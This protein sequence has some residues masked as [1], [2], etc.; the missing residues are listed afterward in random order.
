MITDSQINFLYLADTLPKK[1]PDFYECFEQVLKS[2]KI[3]FALLP[4]TKDVWAVDYM[5]IQTAP[6]RFVR[7]LYRPPYLTESKRDVKTISDV[8]PVLLSVFR[9]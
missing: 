1:Y 6:D 9:S 8:A 3:D 5:P 2:C 7:F 4:E